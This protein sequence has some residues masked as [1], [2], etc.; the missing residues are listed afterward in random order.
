MWD[1]FDP[2]MPFLVGAA[3][4]LISLGLL[5]WMHEPRPEVALSSTPV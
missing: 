2:A 5:H 3:V 4:A 1:T